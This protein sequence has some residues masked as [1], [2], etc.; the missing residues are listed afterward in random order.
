MAD[1]K[2]I[3]GHPCLDFVNTVGGRVTGPAAVLRDK[4]TDYGTLAGW[5]HSAGLSNIREVRRLKRDARL[6]PRRAARTL[7]RAVRLREA[8]YRIFKSLLEGRPPPNPA[9]NVLRLEI[10]AARAHQQLRVSGVGF[11]WALDDSRDT[12]DAPL[13]RISHSSAE[14]LTSAAVTQLRQCGGHECGW[15][16]LDTSRNRKRR[17]CDM[18]DCGNRAKV[19]RFRER[20][21]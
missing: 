4:L 2:F 7:V 13:W 19:R 10:S 17:W 20:H 16:F 1:M 9:I 12:L 11:A 14:L 3:A 6:N 18:K 8:L 5:S 21:T 15:L